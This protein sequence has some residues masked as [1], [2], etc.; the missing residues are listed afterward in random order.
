MLKINRHMQPRL[1]P[2]RLKNKELSPRFVE[3]P[4]REAH[5]ITEEGILMHAALE[6]GDDS[7]LN[8]DQRELVG[9]CRSW[10]QQHQAKFP[11]AQ[12]E[13]TLEI[14]PGTISPGRADLV[15]LTNEGLDAMLV[16]FKFG[17][18]LQEPTETNPAAQAYALG[19]FR[20]FE[21]VRSVDIAYLYPRLGTV[22]TYRYLRVD[23]H[24][25][26]TRMAA[27]EARVAEA[28]RTGV[29]SP[30]E[31]TCKYCGLL[32]TCQ[33]MHQVY[34][35]IA[36]RY[37]DSGLNQKVAQL[38][39]EV[40][41]YD[42]S[43]I[44]DPATMRD[45]LAVASVLEKWCSSVKYHAGKLREE[46]VSVPGYEWSARSGRRTITNP[47]LAYEALKDVISLEQFLGAVEVRITPLMDAVKENA[48]NRKKKEAA[49]RV[50]DLLRD[51]G[52]LEVGPDTFTLQRSKTE[53]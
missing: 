25:I 26:E 34:L 31:E 52:L 46:G 13:L 48:P 33:Q 12:R 22:D 32:A 16:D 3:D 36:T 15:L 40:K 20:R 7:K 24:R 45:A 29:C 35:P 51:R 27:I 14:M 1:T 11:V 44:R 10:L 19:I 17:L 39:Q 47:T 37:A 38:Q 18:K 50:E 42:P 2:S 28:E 49:Q 6:T 30:N 4:N 41:S 43:L 53:G 8:E 5:P 9:R 21:R 23:C